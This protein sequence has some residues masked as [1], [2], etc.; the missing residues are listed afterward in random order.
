MVVLV[1]VFLHTK[2]EVC[3]YSRSRDIDSKA[4]ANC[5]LY[6]SKWAEPRIVFIKYIWINHKVCETWPV[7]RQTY[8]HLPSLRAS[9][10]FDRCQVILLGDRGTQGKSLVWS[11]C[12]SM[13]LTPINRKFNAL[14]IAPPSHHWGNLRW[15]NS[16]K[17]KLQ[18]EK[19]RFLRPIVLYW[20]C[21]IVQLCWIPAG[22]R[23][24]KRDQGASLSIT[25]RCC[26]SA[27]RSS[28]CL[29]G[30][31][32]SISICRKP[33]LQFVRLVKCNFYRAT[34]NV[35]A[36][37]RWEFCASVCPSNACI[38]TKPKN[39]LSR[40]LYHAKDHLA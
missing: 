25:W 2:F 6:C 31:P 9:P 23:C 16:L 27:M 30:C 7:R 26:H 5:D 15:G 1:I 32:T 33:S 21:G 34:W 13:T 36:V 14:P 39:N 35:D 12:R 11:H 40:F 17:Q 22:W 24:I 8:G 19:R 38:V 18:V 37:L 4:K 20:L 3:S 29:C 10:P 28:H